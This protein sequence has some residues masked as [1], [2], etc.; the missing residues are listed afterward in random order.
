[1]YLRSRR[2]YDHLAVEE[3]DTAV[4]GWRL[5]AVAAL[6]A[7]IAGCGDDGKDAGN[8]PA[9]VVI[10]ED[11]YDPA[12]LR[13]A[14]GT[15]VTFVNRSKERSQSAMDDPTGMLDVSP[16]PGATAHDGSE[17]NRASRKGFTTHALFP[18]EWQAVIFPVAGRYEYT[19]AFDSSL[20]GTI[21]VVRDDG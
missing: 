12:T 10:T 21:E 4:H 11:G 19:S 7:S 6:I 1:L 3:G 8:G 18:G 9:R 13:I 2:G 14:P 20:A 16:Q 15:R 5:L 17:V